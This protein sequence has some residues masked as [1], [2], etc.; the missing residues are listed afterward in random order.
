MLN[1]L[2]GD[3]VNLVF[4]IIE[5]MGYVGIA[6]LIAAENVFPP[7]PS[8]AVLPAAGFISTEG[9]FSA[10]LVVVASSVGALIGAYIL[11]F[12]GKFA[13]NRFLHTLLAKY[14]RYVL[15]EEDDL[16]KSE[17][18]FKKHGEPSILFGRMVPLV[19]SLISVPAGYVGMPLWKFTIYT[20]I[21]SAIWNIILVYAGV[22]LGE[23]WEV[24]GTYVSEF[25]HV[26]LAIILLV[27]LF[28]I[29]KR[30]HLFKTWFS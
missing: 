8:E 26:V 22:L 4:V 25:Q 18:W 21:G 19:R 28:F 16:D 3:F 29:Y 24:V 2:L 11:Y 20:T 6:L 15:M 9:K 23:N 14:G 17:E 30:R 5:K 1:N 10:P 12:I 7:I 13:N 27:G